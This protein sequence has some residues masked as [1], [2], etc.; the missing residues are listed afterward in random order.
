MESNYL[1]QTAWETNSNFDLSHHLHIFTGLNYS[2][3]FFL[4]LFIAR[5][6]LHQKF[7]VLMLKFDLLA[8]WYL[9]AGYTVIKYTGKR[10]RGLYFCDFVCGELNLGASVDIR[11]RL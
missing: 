6:V 5:F 10:T 4:C 3:P 2:A 9:Q 7:S 8:K 1:A 11:R